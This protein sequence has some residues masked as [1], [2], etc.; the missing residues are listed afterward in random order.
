VL[1]IAVTVGAMGC[2]EQDTPERGGLSDRDER[3]DLVVMIANRLDR[4]AYVAREPP[5]TT[6]DAR[7]RSVGGQLEKDRRLPLS[8]RPPLAVAGDDD[9][10]RFFVNVL[11]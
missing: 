8:H 3:I 7:K 11:R 2:E 6:F 5:L 9:E 4:F 10:A 1:S